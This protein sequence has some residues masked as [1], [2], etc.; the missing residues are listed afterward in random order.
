MDHINPQI[1]AGWKKVLKDEF[2]TSYFSEL[3]DFLDQTELTRSIF[4]SD[5]A[6]NYLA[7]KGILGRD[8]QTLLE[9]I[10]SV[11]KNP[12]SANLRK[13]EERGL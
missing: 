2:N 12:V 9:K 10:D 13:E 6:S 11:L 7:L 5:H 1:E 3:K 8:K 4:R